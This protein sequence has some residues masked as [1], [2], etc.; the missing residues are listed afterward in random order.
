[1]WSC[2]IICIMYDYMI[3]HTSECVECFYNSY[4]ASNRMYTYLDNSA[5][6]QRKI[7][8]TF[9][10]FPR[11]CSSQSWGASIITSVTISYKESRCG[12]STTLGLS[13]TSPEVWEDKRLATKGVCVCA[14]SFMFAL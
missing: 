13:G 1:V 12:T 3:L 8:T 2:S 4:V 10:T 7:A 14:S 6:F 11:L 9:I 5:L